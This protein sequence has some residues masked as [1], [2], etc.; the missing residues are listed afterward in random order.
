MFHATKQRTHETRVGTDARIA[1][2][3]TMTLAHPLV[4]PITGPFV[5]MATAAKVR[6]CRC[7]AYAAKA[8]YTDA[9]V[10]A[11]ALQLSVQEFLRGAFRL[12]L[13]AVARH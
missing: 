4:L 13:A 3:A 2:P 11:T 8:D 1:S 5:G 9:S 12:S 10:H 7:D 6:G